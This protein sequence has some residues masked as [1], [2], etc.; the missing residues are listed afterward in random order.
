MNHLSRWLIRCYPTWWQQRYAEEFLALLAQ[1]PPTVAHI[2][3]ILRAARD[4]HRRALTPAPTKA[5]PG[6]RLATTGLLASGVLLL[7]V[8]LIPHAVSERQTETLVFTVPLPLL[9]SLPFFV[10]AVARHQ[11]RP[12]PLP[13]LGLAAGVSALCAL[14]LA[15]PRLHEVPGLLP[16]AVFVALCMT[17]GMWLAL[18]NA[19][20][21]RGHLAPRWMLLAGIVAGLSWCALLASALLNMA[22]PQGM[23]AVSAL[24]SASLLIW[25]VSQPVWT[26][27]ACVWLWRSSSARYASAV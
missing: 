27:A 14:G 25:L 26:A 10:C 3:D 1:Q 24:L 8:F 12:L 16:A 2:I 23:G 20:G 6:L 17:L 13:G 9:A 4:E 21:L 19:N 5:V 11:K 7:V 22:Y 15:L 18:V